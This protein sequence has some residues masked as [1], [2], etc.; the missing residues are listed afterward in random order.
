MVVAEEEDEMVKAQVGDYHVGQ[1]LKHKLRKHRCK[2]NDTIKTVCQELQ[3]SDIRDV[4]D[5]NRRRLYGTNPQRFYRTSRLQPGQF[6]LVPDETS[7]LET[8]VVAYDG[9]IKLKSGDWVERWQGRDDKD[10][11]DYA[12]EAED[13]F[14]GLQAGEATWTVDNEMVG[15]DVIVMGDR[16]RIVAHLPPTEEDPAPLWKIQFNDAGNRVDLEE[17]E[18]HEAL[19]RARGTANPGGIIGVQS[20]AAGEQVEIH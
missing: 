15:K 6:M 9:W 16:A 10:G 3:I 4:Y 12:L 5:L 17:A 14:T 1:V 2:E 20:V 18:L 13:L 11:Q 7:I 8:T 19:A